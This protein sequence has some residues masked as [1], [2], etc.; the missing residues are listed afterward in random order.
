MKI[1]AIDKTISDIFSPKNVKYIVPR[2]QREYS[3]EKSQI[4]ELWKDIN[5]NIKKVG[6]EYK[7][8][9]Y[10][11]GPLV[12]IGDDDT[13]TVDI[14]K[15]FQIVDGQ[16]RL[17]TVTI[18]L[19]ALVQVF[20]RL[21]I[22]ESA[23]GLYGYIEGSDDDSN[24]FFKLVNENPKPYFQNSIQRYEQRVETPSSDEERKLKDSYNLIIKEL[25]DKQRGFVNEFEFTNYLKALRSQI[26]K[27]KTIFIT[28]D[29]EEEAYTIFETL[30]ARGINLAAVDL[31]K[32][33][34][35]KVLNYN[36]PDDDA[37]TIWKRIR[38]NLVSNKYSVNMD[39]F[40]RHYWISK[41][42]FSTQKD[43]YKSFKRLINL[44]DNDPDKNLK[45]AL[46]FLNDLEKES[47]YYMIV[48]NSDEN[49]WTRQEEK[50]IH[51]SLRALRLFG[52]TQVNTILIS[53][54]YLYK[55]NKLNVNDFADA[56]DYLEKFHFIYSTISSFRTSTIE[57]K[58]SK[59]ARNFRGST[60]KAQSKELIKQMKEDFNE[61]LPGFSAFSE[62]FSKLWYTKEDDSDKKII[63]YIFRKIENYYQ[64]TQELNVYKFTLEHINSQKN[65]SYKNDV[66]KIGNLLPLSQPINE[67]AGVLKFA[68][69]VTI[70][71]KSGFEIAKE[72]T[73]KYETLPDWDDSLIQARTQELA[74]LAYEEVWEIV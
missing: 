48:T 21:G 70:Y 23:M 2:F 35:F 71:K 11:I 10:F 36:H 14:N 31:V 13:T 63:Q 47:K 72:F 62:G 51:Q 30:N 65:S 58:Y 50:N 55:N 67:E 66:G 41:F 74:K 34:L 9:E 42:E 38:T 39:V 32:N 26:L 53:L 22:K 61:K 46:D 56:V 27:L 17:T 37:Q 3:W 25:D 69:K 45:T 15:E 6:D 40:F 18:I 24:A 19:S 20:K 54:L 12:L 49:H 73:R 64:A 4:L 57:R 28:V 43:L 8:L 5:D 60:S 29:S 16:Q 7:V 33:S 68:D 1:H 59:N 44:S 52:G